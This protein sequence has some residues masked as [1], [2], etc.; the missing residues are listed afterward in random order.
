[1]RQV[2]VDELTWL[3]YSGLRSWT[4]TVRK[5]IFAPIATRKDVLRRIACDK[6]VI[7][8]K[9]H[10]F[11]DPE[12][13]Y[14]AASPEALAGRLVEALGTLPGAIPALW[15]SRVDARHKEAQTATAVIFAEALVGY[16]IVSETPRGIVFKFP[17]LV[18]P[19]HAL[20]P[21]WP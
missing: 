5:G 20:Q 19:P 14:A 3:L 9:P 12:N 11:L 17:N 18:A 4:W 15:L 7:P 21:R 6:V 1:M 8:L 10:E 16:E 2:N 13:A